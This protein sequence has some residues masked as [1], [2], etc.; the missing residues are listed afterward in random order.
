MENVRI[1]R[2]VL[3]DMVAH[4]GAEA[5]RECCGLLVGTADDVAESV[6]TDNLEPG[7]ARFRVDPAA[8]FRL[9]K[10]LRGTS[11]EIV[12]A[13]HSH[14][15]SP[16]VPSPTDIAEAVSDDFLCVI[17]SLANPAGPVIRA[18][19]LRGGAAYELGV[20]ANDSPP[21]IL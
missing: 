5:P 10:K 16:A 6:R 18:F 19:R 13:Y 12:G 14:P 3:D 15:C 1:A 21:L 9:I 8:H 17:V 20:Q 11:R 2:A 4:A 7:N